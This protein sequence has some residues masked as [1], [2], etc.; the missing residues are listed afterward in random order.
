MKRETGA[1]PILATP[2]EVAFDDLVAA[3]NDKRTE[4]AEVATTEL[5]MPTTEKQDAPS[6][7]TS[8]EDL[9]A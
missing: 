1:F 6:D 4:E 8:E 9:A 5:G 7:N 3:Q 2:E